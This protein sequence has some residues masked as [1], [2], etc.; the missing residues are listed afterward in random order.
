MPINLKS[1]LSSKRLFIDN[2]LI[3]PIKDKRI[4]VLVEIW[5]KQKPDTNDK[6]I[7]R[8]IETKNITINEEMKWNYGGKTK[9][10]NNATNNVQFLFRWKISAYSGSE[11]NLTEHNCP[12]GWK[13]DNCDEPICMDSC[14]PSHGYRFQ[15][16]VNFVFNIQI[17]SCL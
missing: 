3:D 17:V 1:F 8:Y 13:G 12:T 11:V 10:Q 15:T 16:Y 2:N 5:N 14:D 9:K 6:L 4:L 7:A